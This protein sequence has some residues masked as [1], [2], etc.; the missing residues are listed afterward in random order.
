MSKINSI[1]RQGMASKDVATIQQALVDTKEPKFNPGPVDGVFGPKTLAAIKEVQ[2]KLKTGGSG[3]IGPKTLAF[4]GITVEAV[5]PLNGHKTITQDFKGKLDRRLHP[6]TRLALEKLVFPN[7]EVP[8]I[9]PNAEI[10]KVYVYIASNMA[11]LGWKERGGN[12]KGTEIGWVQDTTGSYTEG[13]N[14][15]AWCLD[16]AQIIFAFIEDYYQI[17]SPVPATAHCVTCWNGA[18]KV[19]GLTSVKPVVG[20]LALGQNK[21]SSS[22]HA[23]PTV[24]VNEEEGTMLTVEGNTSVKNMT[25]GDGSGMKTRNIKKNGKLVTLG[26]VY[27]YPNNILPVKPA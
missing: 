4:L 7:G 8:D 10:E 23:M 21:P 2:K 6:N 5:D 13:G 1:P 3:I 15:D 19:K 12:N 16:W 20:A 14:G 24:K 17:E 25:D 18:K 11:K 9:F 27:T 22:G 26:W